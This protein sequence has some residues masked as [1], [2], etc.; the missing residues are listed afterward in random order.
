VTIPNFNVSQRINSANLIGDARG[1]PGGGPAL[2][3]ETVAQNFGIRVDKYILVNFDAFIAIV[4]TIAPD[5]IE[6]CPKERIY[7]DHYP[8]NLYGTIVVTFKPGCQRLDAERLLQYARTRATSRSDFDRAERQQEVLDAARREVLNAGG[9]VHFASQVPV[10]YEQLLGSFSTNLTP[11]EI[12]QLGVLMSEIKDE[13]IHRAVIDT[14]YV[15][16]GTT[17]EGDQILI[18]QQARISDLIQRVFFP[19]NQLDLADL[20]T[21]ASVEN[22]TI[23]VFNGTDIA[24]LAGATREWLTSRGVS[25]GEIGNLPTVTNA[26]T[27]IKEYGPYPATARYLAALMRLPQERIQPGTDGLM[28]NGVAVIVGPDIQSLLQGG[29]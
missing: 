3:M 24:G 28:A 14:N 17:P 6:V 4:N 5:G 12:I 21:R 9:I 23:R 2:A 7:D 8:D 27:V 1:Y 20:K 22:A 15:M 19:Q 29:E 13:D 16:L 26:N 10:L 11:G 18:P 25:V